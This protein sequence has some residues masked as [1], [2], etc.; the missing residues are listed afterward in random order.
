MTE[1]KL[2]P[3]LTYTTAPPGRLEAHGSSVSSAVGAVG[4][5]A[6]PTDI[7]GFV[8]DFA[9][10]RWGI[11]RAI[12]LEMIEYGDPDGG[13][14]LKR[15]NQVAFR[16]EVVYGWGIQD[17]TAFAAI[18]GAGALDFNWTAA[19]TGTGSYVYTVDGV[20]T[21]PLTE[22]STVAE[23]SA[24]LNAAGTA[25]GFDVTGTP[26]SYS[27][28]CNNGA[29]LAVDNTALVALTVV[30]PGTTGTKKTSKRGTK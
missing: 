4:V 25:A 10:I 2:Y 15:N 17:L 16:A 18:T 20:A 13:G 3:D 14:D 9:G 1:Q 19:V 30:P 24:A 8:G 5:A 7:L 29:K 11:Q 22:T 27:I 26:A 23:V 6:T 28:L 12:G 21:P